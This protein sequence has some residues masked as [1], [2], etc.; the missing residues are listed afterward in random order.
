[1]L[2]FNSKPVSEHSEVPLADD[3]ELE[4]LIERFSARDAE[5]IGPEDSA[6][7]VVSVGP[8][9]DPIA[10]AA[11]QVHGAVADRACGAQHRHAARGGRRGLV[12]TQRYSAH[13][14]TK[15]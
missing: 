1:M 14:L 2:K 3:G 8:D 12:V 9:R 7:Y 10:R 6:C 13:S 15:P 5:A 4:K 11:Q